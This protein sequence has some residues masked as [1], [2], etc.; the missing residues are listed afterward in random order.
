MSLPEKRGKK[1]IVILYFSFAVHVLKTHLTVY[2]LCRSASGDLAE[3]IKVKRQKLLTIFSLTEKVLQAIFG[4]LV[5]R[6]P[7][8]QEGMVGASQE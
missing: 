1:N 7:L 2:Y 4:T 8:S 5:R 3:T 6:S